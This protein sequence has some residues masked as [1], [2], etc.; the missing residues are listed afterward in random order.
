[1]QPPQTRSGAGQAAK[2]KAAAANYEQNNP[3]A[4]AAATGFMMGGK[5]PPM[6]AALFGK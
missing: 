5:Q 6:Q 3:F 1:M 2:P 4:S